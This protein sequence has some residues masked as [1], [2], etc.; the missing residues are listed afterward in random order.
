MVLKCDSK[1]IHVSKLVGLLLWSSV[2][3]CF[4]YKRALCIILVIAMH[5]NDPLFVWTLR[6]S[7]RHLREVSQNSSSSE[8]PK[9]EFSNQNKG[10]NRRKRLVI[11]V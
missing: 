8:Q 1:E 5:I 7:T 11:T 3:L 2:Q 10:I 4:S 6:L 9:P